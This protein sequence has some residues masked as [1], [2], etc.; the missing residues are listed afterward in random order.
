MSRIFGPLRQL[1]YVVRDIEAAMEHWIGT[2]GVGPFFLIERVPLASF[3]YMGRPS[4]PDMAIALTFSGSA[5]IELIQQRNDAPSMYMDYLAAGQEGLQHIAYWPED[6]AAARAAALGRGME[7]GQEG[8]IPGRGPFVYFRTTGHHGTC[9]E[10][11][12]FNAFRRYQ[13]TE[14]A[15]ICAEW[16]G[17]DPIRTVLPAP[18]D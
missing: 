4:E 13:S 11:A 8:E 15:R 9:V 1:G 6:Y 3:T 5:Q 18:P 7:V 12:E 16:D 2:N 10:F 14:M 17:S